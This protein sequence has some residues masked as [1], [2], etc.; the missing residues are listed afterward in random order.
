M[1]MVEAVWITRIVILKLSRKRNSSTTLSPHKQNVEYVE[2]LD[3]PG[4][5]QQHALNVAAR[6]YTSRNDFLPH[7]AQESVQRP[8]GEIPLPARK[9]A[10]L[11]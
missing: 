11:F 6:E 4:L 3:E 2:T 8:L 1:R 7:R 9:E 10:Q 5:T